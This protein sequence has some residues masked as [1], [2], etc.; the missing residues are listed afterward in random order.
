MLTV[1][2]L[3]LLVVGVAIVFATNGDLFAQTKTNISGTGGIHEIRG[4][5]YAP[6]GTILNS[7]VQITLE[8][9]AYPSLSLLTD[10]SA[11]YSFKN[12]APGSYTVVINAGEQFEIADRKSVV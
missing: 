10:S 2:V 12:L 8:S 7:P 1:R 6:D 11:S 3:R 9:T 5:I 4:R